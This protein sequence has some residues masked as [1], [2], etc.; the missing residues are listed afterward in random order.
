MSYNLIHEK[1]IPV[2]YADGRVERVG[3]LDALI[4]AH[5]IHSIVASNPMDRLSVVRF[6]LAVLYW[7]R[8]SPPSETGLSP[9]EPFPSNWFDK[10]LD[11]AEFF[12]LLGDDRRFYQYRASAVS[13]ETRLSTT[14]LLHEIPSGTNKSHFRSAIDGVSGLCPACCALGLLRLPVFA[15]SAGRGKAPGINRKPPFYAVPVGHS[16]ASTLRLSW[17]PIA[18]LGTPAWEQPEMQLPTSGTVSLLT[19][20][21]WLPRRVW[22]DPPEP[23]EGVC[24]GCGRT[25]SLILRSVFAGLGST[26]TSTDSPSREWVDP[27]VMT[28]AQGTYRGQSIQAANVFRYPSAASGQWA[29]V[30]SN[31]ARSGLFD[32]CAAP[33]G[34]LGGSCSALWVIGFATVQNDKYLEVI[35]YLIPVGAVRPISEDGLECIES[36]VHDNSNLAAK[37]RLSEYGNQVRPHIGFTASLR[38]VRPHAEAEAFSKVKGLLHD[39]ELTAFRDASD[40][41]RRLVD[42]VAH[43]LCPGFTVAAIRKRQGVIGCVSESKYPREAVRGGGEV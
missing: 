26:K 33:S 18:E 10:L 12:N 35:D 22:L 19:G 43:S 24:I 9:D 29:S 42:E 21:T 14:Y 11:H 40:Q 8:G 1:W 27:H 6:L 5:R 38:A 41:R 37:I 23:T 34:S 32:A 4:D 7:C 16:L 3:I 31:A 20:L 15:T 30:I 28:Y 2:L 36:W 25:A 17:R 39:D 13:S